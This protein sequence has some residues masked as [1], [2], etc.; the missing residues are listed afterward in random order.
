M[1][2]TRLNFK[3]K[4]KEKFI[5]T[6][7][8][9]NIIQSSTMSKA[10]VEEPTSE[11]WYETLN[12]YG[13]IIFKNNV[14]YEGF[15]KYG[16]LNNEDPENPCTINFP[17]GTKYVGTI[18]NNE[19]TGE[20]IY[21]FEDGSTYKGEVLNGLRE[22]KG[23]YQTL[24]GIYYEGEWKN[25][26]KHGKGKIIQGNMEL[27]GEWVEGVLNGK[28]RIKWKSG[29]LFDGELVDNNMNGNG[30]MIWFNKNEK[31]SGMWKNNLQNGYG[32]H[33]WYDS[34]NENKFFRDRYVG[35]WKDGKREGYG[36][37]YYSNGN[38]YEGQWKNNQKEGFG[39]FYYQDRTK[40][41]GSFKKDNLIE[42]INIKSNKDRNEDMNK[43]KTN[44]PKDKKSRINK[45]IDE[46]KIQISINDLINT[47]PETKKSLKEIDNLIL[48][49]LSLITHLYLYASGKDD[50]KSMDLGL[51]SLGA[52][53]TND[54]RNIYK[55]YSRRNSK[56]NNDNTSNNLKQIDQQ[57]TQTE[58]KVEKAIDYDNVYNNDVY[59]CLDF[60][61]FWKLIRECGLITPEFSLAMI[62]RI[63]FQNPD[64]IIEMFY[65]PEDLSRKNNVKGEKEEIYDYIYKIIEKSKID[66]E[67]KYKSQIE[68]SQALIYGSSNE[69]DKD[70][71]KDKDIDKDKDK[72]K[73]KNDDKNK[74]DKNKNDDKNKIDKNKNDDKNK[75]QEK[76]I[77]EENKK[78]YEET[79]NYHDD[80][81]VILLRYFYEIIIRIAYI[82]YND[83]PNMSIV[84]RLKILLEEL[85]SFL[86]AKIKS[87]NV[88]SSIAASILMID[89]KLKNVD[90]LLDKFISDNCINLNK[91]FID[92][93]EYSC[94]NEYSYKSYDMTITY[95]FFYDN[96]ILNSEALSK[97]FKNKMEYIDIISIYIKDKKLNSYNLGSA[98]KMYN[99]YEIM[100]YLDYLLDY[101]MIFREFCELIFYISRKYF[102]F[103]GIN[104]E[105]EENTIIN[106]KNISMSRR[107]EELKKKQNRNRKLTRIENKEEKDAK[108][109]K[110]SKECKENKEIDNYKIVIN[111][112]IQE[113]DKLISGDKYTGVDH[114]TY[115]VLKA[116]QTITKLKENEEKRKVEEEMRDKE[117]QRYTKER[118]LLKEEDLN[119]YKEE[120]EQENTSESFDE[121]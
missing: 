2:E 100:E 88:D 97:V 47:E 66:F 118:D 84:M 65:I 3:L 7:L 106:N 34:K 99:S 116:H 59:F 91:I 51:S 33:I 73:N 60:L 87:G 109:S 64:N 77:I 52:T 83:N 55:Q 57:I 108:E 28:C 76:E 101:E 67:N 115:P 62:D 56:I 1:S 89:P 119:V 43:T 102:I 81:N 44:Y 24:D 32:I 92:L 40:Y 105:E 104:K 48:R 78:E 120:E 35:E 30:Y 69:K 19:I 68:K 61:H 54:T 85:K 46:I 42:S 4:P 95:R 29:N 37:F 22:G 50:F 5:S 53:L 6:Q 90:T 23:S 86:R 18:I 71:N 13:K 8:L 70:K 94:D 74:K 93:Y 21:T 11:L 38:I 79:L 58:K 10:V 103:Y 20:G 39:I 17:D 49:N 121:D 82:R 36:K 75:N 63:C 27:E 12:G 9:T 117:K 15:L 107:N 114:Y 72:D 80:K 16:I 98:S 112:I 26:L 31:F 96:I 14:T 25:G 41:I 111:Y 110:E 45:N 113:K